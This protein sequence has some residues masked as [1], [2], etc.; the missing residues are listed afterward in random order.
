MKIL[1]VSY[2]SYNAGASLI[3]D[4]EVVASVTEERLN[5]IKYCNSFPFLAIEYCL[6]RAGLKFSDLDVIALN[7]NPNIDMTNWN[8]VAGNSPSW[9]PEMLVN[10][11]SSIHKLA[12]TNFSSDHLKVT[13]D[14]D[15]KSVNLIFVQH[16]YCHIA[17]SF[18]LSDFDTSICLSLDG[19]GEK[20]SGLVVRASGRKFENLETF[21]YPNSIGLLYGTFTSY[22][23]YQIDKDEWKVMGLASY[24]SESYFISLVKKVAYFV[25]DT[26][27][28]DR[29]Y[30][31]YFNKASSAPYTDIFDELFQCRREPNDPITSAH[32]NLAFAVQAVVEEYVFKIIRRLKDASPQVN[33]ICLAGGVFMN[34]VLVG[35]LAESKIFE[36]LYVNAFPDDTGTCLGA[37]LHVLQSK[38][39]IKNNLFGPSVTNAQVERKLEKYGLDYSYYDDISLVTAKEVC[40]GKVVGWFQG[41]MEFGQRALGSRSILAD[42]RDVKNKDRLNRKI[43]YRESFRPFA[44]SVLDQD[45]SKFFPNRAPCYFMEKTTMATDEFKEKF[46]A[47]VHVDGTCRV[48]TVDSN[49]N[50][51]FYD[52]LERVRELTG[53]GVLLNTS[54]NL[55]GEPIVATLEDALKSFFTSGIDILVVE[56]Y[57]IRKR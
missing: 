54:F 22:L 43:K 45:Y 32:K 28:V 23:G 8:R 5:R 41:G 20:D 52:L 56:N 47:G 10:T 50:S 2:L 12:K 37:A 16:H 29:N 33:N 18:Y 57:L 44:P 48:Q 25:N 15:G 34:S 31:D 38:V 9:F 7:A 4:G 11:I 30:F 1:G 53:H 36:N 49:S 24:G 42:A 17:S 14:I 51:V 3:V 35:K 39:S 6:L 40:A 46:P 27:L 55:N 19:R 21:Q 26:F 13:F